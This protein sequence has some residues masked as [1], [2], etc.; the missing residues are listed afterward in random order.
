MKKLLIKNLILFLIFAIHVISFAQKKNT[1]NDTKIED[2]N[3]R[4]FN[5]LIK[6]AE[7]YC[8]SRYVYVA[9]TLNELQYNE[10][11]RL[12]IEQSLIYLGYYI[13]NDEI[14]GII[15]CT[16][17]RAIEDF[18]KDNGLIINGRVD[19]VTAVLIEKKILDKRFKK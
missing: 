15:T 13:E 12:W 6:E 9:I 18:Q 14:D 8:G 3:T 16:T 7:P 4:I 17:I 10:R 2:S 5:M 11:M 19:E 1:S